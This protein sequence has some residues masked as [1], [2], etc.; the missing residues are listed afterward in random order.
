MDTLDFDPA[1][2]RLAFEA[3]REAARK[4]LDEA[5]LKKLLG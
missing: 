4:P 5:E 1:K 3:G 2:I